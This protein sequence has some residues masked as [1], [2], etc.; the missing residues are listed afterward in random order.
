MPTYHTLAVATPEGLRETSKVNE[1]C[2]CGAKLPPDARFCHKCGKP[3]Y[4][5]PA[6]LEVEKAIAPPLPPIIVP[7]PP[8]LTGISFQNSA[9]VRVAFLVAAIVTLLISFPMPALFAF[10]WQVILLL[11]G[12]FFSVWL[13]ARR[14]GQSLTIGS[15]ARMGWIT[16]V[17]CFV[18]MIIF[19]S[20]SL[21]AVSANGSIITFFREAM[22]QR[23][24][25]E[26]TEQFEQIL[27]NRTA[28][29]AML[30]FILFLFF[31]MMTLTSAVGGALGAKVL[32]KE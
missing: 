28:F 7:P 21:L 16:G 31:L 1:N 12:G 14:T 5:D 23:G 24:T 22:S 29:G 3:Q 9:A 8:S 10:A 18:I 26:L 15:G 17:F 32:E 19:F 20:L 6:F 13:Y 27:Q 11:A 30:I 2:T 4:E 25:P